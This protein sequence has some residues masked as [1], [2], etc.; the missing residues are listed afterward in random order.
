MDTARRI[1]EQPK[2]E[3]ALRNFQFSDL[4]RLAV[5]KDA[6]AIAAAESAADAY[7]AY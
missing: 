7:R 2:R 4:Q 1:G 6:G 3:S 5:R